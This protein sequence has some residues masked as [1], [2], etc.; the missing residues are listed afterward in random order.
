MS[1]GKWRPFCLGL[2]VLRGYV[3]IEPAPTILYLQNAFCYVYLTWKICVLCKYSQN[4]YFSESPNLYFSFLGIQ[5][6]NAIA[7]ICK[8]LNQNGICVNKGML[9]SL[10]I[11]SIGFIFLHTHFLGWCSTK[12]CI[13][14]SSTMLYFEAKSV[15]QQTMS[16]ISILNGWLLCYIGNLKCHQ[17]Q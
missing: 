16:F 6:K 12:I 17:I 7:Y 14:I 11:I 15:F 4:L 13:F 2:S 8:R 10:I 1:S 3:Y 5:I 9:V